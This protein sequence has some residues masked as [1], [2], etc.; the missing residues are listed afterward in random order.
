MD[1]QVYIFVVLGEWK[2]VVEWQDVDFVEIMVCYICVMVF[3][4]ILG[5]QFVVVVEMVVYGFFVLWVGYVLVICFVDDLSVC[6]LVIDLKFGFDIDMVCVGEMV[7]MVFMGFVLWLMV[8]VWFDGIRLMDV[9]V[10]VEGVL[11]M[12][13]LIFVNV[14]VGKY[15]VIVWDVVGVEFVSVL[16]KV[17]K[18]KLGKKVIVMVFIGLVVVGLSVIVQLRGFEVYVLV[19]LWLYFEFVWIGEVIVLVEGDV[20]VIVMILVLILV[21]VYVLVVIDV[22]GV[23]LVW[24]DFVVMV[25]MGSGSGGSGGSFV[26]MGVDGVIWIGVVFVVLFMMGFGLI[27]WL[28]RC[29]LS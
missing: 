6:N 27:L 17:K 1:G 13:L 16:L 10:D 26:M 28:W 2:N 7:G 9:M 15:W 4:L 22:Q 8:L 11:M 20:V 18:V 3:F 12:W 21:G 25:V 23:E 5:I 19:Q 29:C 14:E 24:G